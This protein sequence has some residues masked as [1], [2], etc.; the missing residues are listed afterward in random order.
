MSDTDTEVISAFCDGESVDP[1]ALERAIADP[2]GRQLLVDC[3]RLRDAFRRDEGA[4][5]PSLAKMRRTP[6]PRRP[7]TPFLRLAAALLLG[8][9]V[10]SYLLPQERGSQRSPPAAARVVSFEPGVDWQ[11][12]E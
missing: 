6:V 4:L 3:A 2:A 11:S 9:G 1:D 10:G 5:P 12:G 8:I 7:A